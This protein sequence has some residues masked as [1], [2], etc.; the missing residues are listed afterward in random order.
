[1]RGPTLSGKD[2]VHIDPWWRWEL[3][4][5]TVVADTPSG[6]MKR[7]AFSDADFV[8]DNTDVLGVALTMKEE[9]TSWLEIAGRPNSS[10]TRIGEFA[11]LAP[12]HSLQVH[13]E[14]DARFLLL[15]LS[16]TA[17]LDG[18]GDDLEIQLDRMEFATRFGQQD[19]RLERALMRLALADAEEAPEATLAVASGLALRHSSLAG[20]R[21]AIHRAGICPASLRRV[22][23]RVEDE[24]TTVLALPDLART[25]GLSPFHFAREFHRSTGYAPHQYVVRRRIARAFRLFGSTELP[26]EEIARLAGFHRGSH[27][28]RHLRRQLGLA[29][30]QLR[31]LLR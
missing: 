14:G 11:I 4:D 1:M 27:M 3:D 29:P 21:V 10:T 28:A 16:M 15:G 26:I 19:G 7:S 12:G 5:G 20:D 18:L 13:L 8:I 17:L 23:D 2:L 22:L 30:G 9:Y 31:R 25:A 24:V 6:L